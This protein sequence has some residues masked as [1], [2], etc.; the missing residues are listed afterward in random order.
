MANA[1]VHPLRRETGVYFPPG[2][3]HIWRGSILLKRSHRI[4]IWVRKILYY[5]SNGWA[6]CP[7]RVSILFLRKDRTSTKFS[8]CDV[9]LLDGRGTSLL[10]KVIFL[11][12][13]IRIFFAFFENP[14]YQGLRKKPVIFLV[15]LILLFT[16]YGNCVRFVSEE[17]NEVCTNNLS[18]LRNRVFI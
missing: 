5:S 7:C 4:C 10:S 11:Q 18:V 6:L 13:N 9:T 1:H 2:R 3:L 17:R 12:E 16:G 15:L 14:V 8:E